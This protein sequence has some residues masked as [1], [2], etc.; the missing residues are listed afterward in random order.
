MKLFS[1]YPGVPYTG[2]GIFL[3]TYV[4][5][6]LIGIILIKNAY[7][8]DDTGKSTHEAAGNLENTIKGIDVTLKL[9]NDI[10][11]RTNILSINAEDIVKMSEQIKLINQMA[12]QID[13]LL[14]A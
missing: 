3:S 4:L 8:V 13:D 14:K 6:L 10:A 2:L 1:L 9:I 5:Y 11:F 7:S 12:E